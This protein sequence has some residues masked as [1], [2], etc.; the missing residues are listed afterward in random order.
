MP[1]ALSLKNIRN[2]GI[3]AHIDAGKT[4]T[5][6]RI[7]FYSGKVHRIGEVDEGAATMDWMEQEKERGITITSAAISCTWKKHQINI[8][9]T[10]GHVDFTAEVERSLRVLDGA[11][12]VFCAVGGVEPQSETVWLQADK[13]RIPRLAFVNKMD[14]LGADF[15]RVIDMMHDRLHA[16]TIVLELPVGA[17]DTFDGVID[18]VHQKWLKFHQ[19]DFG[20]TWEELEIPSDMQDTVDHYRH[21]LL[22]TIAEYDDELLEKYLG[23]EAVDAALVRRAVRAATLSGKVVPVLCGAAVRNTGVQQLIDAIVNY[24]PSPLDVHSIQGENPYTQKMEERHADA[25]EPFA[26]LAFKI[27]TDPYVGKLTYCRVYSG[28]IEVGNTALNTSN[29]KKERIQRLIQMSSNKQHDIKK[30]IPGD[31]LAVVGLRNTRTGDTLCDPKHPIM[32]ETLTFPVPVISVAIEP[33]SKA[34]EEKLVD[35]LNSL[36][37]EDPTFQF[38]VDEDTG[39]MLISGMGELHLE[40]IV[41]RLFREFKV[42]ANVG[43]PQVAYRE[44]LTDRIR[45]TTTFDRQAGGKQQFAKVTIE[46]EPLESGGNIFEFEN[47]LDDHILP[48]E[49]IKPIETGISESMTS[50]SIAGYPVINIKAV[51]VDAEYDESESSELA[52]KV[53]GT[54]ALQNA[55]REGSAVL[56]E[57][58]ME[59]EVVTPEDYFGTILSDLAG[60][61]AK[62]IGHGKRGVNQVVDAI[63]PMA[64]MFGYATA[65]RNMSQGRGLFSLQF[66]HYEPVSEEIFKRLLEKMGLAT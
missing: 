38:K 10:P 52:F 18:L 15:Y 4:T 26:A 12:A 59:L 1:K 6:E 51:L 37:D 43:N 8:I 23:G 48:R 31:I 40:I 41:D 21:D 16:N 64:E 60:R 42:K 2:I 14:R 46:F 7:L 35:A 39:Q 22:E 32:L 53:A 54:I 65:L 3:M 57:P 20:A 33:K 27:Q 25:D 36:V 5:T 30:A 44:T 66:K 45:T 24:L 56:M 19:N 9:D 58:V 13:Y 11:V 34:D 63:V 62:I 28:A 47:R 61:R 50:G 55:L 29:G 49:F 17:G